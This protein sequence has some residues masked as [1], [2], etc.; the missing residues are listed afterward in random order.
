MTRS[1]KAIFIGA[2][3]ALLG[4]FSRVVAGPVDD[5]SAALSKG[6]FASALQ[7]VRPLAEQGNP[8]AESLLGEMYEGGYGLPRDAAVATSWDRGTTLVT[9]SQMV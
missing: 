9:F 6:D 8:A 4:A 2:A 1:A 7:I 5:A 3:L